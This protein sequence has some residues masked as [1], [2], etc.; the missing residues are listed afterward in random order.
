MS[1][2]RYPE[3][4]RAGGCKLH[5]R[6]LDNLITEEIVPLACPVCIEPRAGDQPPSKNLDGPS[7]GVR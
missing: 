6:P 4:T 5:A 2:D 3:P 7:Q 1:G